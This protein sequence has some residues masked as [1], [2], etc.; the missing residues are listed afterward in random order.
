MK[1]TIRTALAAALA[2][3]GSG[4][5]AQAAFFSYPRALTL[6]LDKIR[7]ETATLAPIA[8]TRFCLQYPDDCHAHS[9]QYSRPPRPVVLTAAHLEDLIEVNRDVNRAIAP[10]EDTGNFAGRAM[11]RP[12]QKLALAMTTLLLNATNCWRAAGHLGR[13]Y[14]PRS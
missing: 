6:Q 2:I 12:G 10:R 4:Y 7:F 13:C 3:V 1:W 8:Y 9:A 11:D 14:W 5:T